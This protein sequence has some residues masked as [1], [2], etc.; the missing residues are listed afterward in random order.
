MKFRPSA[1]FYQLF[2]APFRET[3]ELS[4]SRFRGYRRNSVSSL[5]I[6][7][8]LKRERKI[9]SSFLSWIIKGLS[10]HPIFPVR[11]NSSN[12]RSYASNTINLIPYMNPKLGIEESSQSSFLSNSI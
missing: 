3:S 9:E 11:S 4:F 6:Y 7:T 5:P 12:A 10:P 8:L 2:H 1:H